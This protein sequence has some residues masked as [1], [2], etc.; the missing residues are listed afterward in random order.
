M[1]NASTSSKFRRKR[2]DP[3]RRRTRPQETNNVVQ[4]EKLYEIRDIKAEKWQGNTLLYLIDWA[5]DRVT[6]EAYENTWVCSAT[7]ASY[8]PR[9]PFVYNNESNLSFFR[10]LPRT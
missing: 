1:L 5:D 8:T 9:P 2:N 7:I 10:S 6:G 4:E 3:G